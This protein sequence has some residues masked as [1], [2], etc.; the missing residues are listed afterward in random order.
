MHQVADIYIRLCLGLITW[1]SATPTPIPLLPWRTP[2]RLNMRF[3]ASVLL[4]E[5]TI[6]LEAYKRVFWES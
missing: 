6:L 2:S 1:E 4:K 3:P 5:V